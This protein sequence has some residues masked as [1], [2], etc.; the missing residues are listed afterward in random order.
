MDVQNRFPP[1][2]ALIGAGLLGALQGNAFGAAAEPEGGKPGLFPGFKQSK[3]KTSGAEINTLVAGNGPPL[4]LLHGHPETHVAW[5]KVAPLLTDGFTVVLTDL[6]GYGDSSKPESGADHATYS[7]RAMGLDQVEVMRAL[8]HTQFQA[9]GHDRGGRVLH[10]MMLDH[11]DTVTRGVVLD[12]APTDLMYAYTDEMFATKYFWWFFHI[13]GQPLPERMIG[14]QT[15][16]YLRSHLHAQSGTPGAVT[17]AAFAEYLRCYQDPACIHAVCEDYRAS[18]TIDRR[19]TEQDR[20]QGR[21]IRQ[22]L[23]AVWGGKGIVAELFDVLSLWRQEADDVEGGELD[24]GHLIP[25]EDPAGL[26][27]ALRAALKA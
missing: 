26:L 17:P 7:K 3:V 13:Q 6:R 11:P 1:R 22:P 20:A 24:C 27:E 5:W 16:L 8:G 14:S 19:H 10:R 12:I 23:F 9:V 21:K 25:E 15:E 2:R 4:L 18:V